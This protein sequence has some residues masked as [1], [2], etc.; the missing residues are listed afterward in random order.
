MVFRDFFTVAII[1]YFNNWLKY[2]YLNKKPIKDI[3]KNGNLQSVVIIFEKPKRYS[4][5]RL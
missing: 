5:K 3:M 2:F 4:E 1:S